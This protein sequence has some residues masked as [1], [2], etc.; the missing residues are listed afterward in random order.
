MQWKERDFNAT[1]VP[2]TIWRLVL[3]VGREVTMQRPLETAYRRFLE[4]EPADLLDLLGGDVVYHLPGRHLGGGCLRGRDAL[5]EVLSRAARA[6][7]GPPRVRV[8]G[9][10]QAGELVVTFEQFRA[11]SRHGVLDQHA[12]VVWRFS[13]GRCVEIWTHF[14]DQDACDAFWRAAGF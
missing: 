10:G 8:L 5:L 2:G 7:D 6:C 11:T 13:L 12:C 1:V 9:A 4:G 14:E 3:G